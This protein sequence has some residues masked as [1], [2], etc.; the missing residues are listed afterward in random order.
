[1]TQLIPDLDLAPGIRY[2]IGCWLAEAGEDELAFGALWESVREDGP[3]PAAA[4][5]L[6]RAGLLAWERLRSPHS[7]REA[8]ERL[9]E[10]FPDSAWTDAARDGLRRLPAAG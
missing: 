3:T 7:A 5:A 10:Q 1:H 6:Y 2:R 4:G 8:W 9:L